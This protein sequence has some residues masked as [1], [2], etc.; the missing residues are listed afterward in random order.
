MVRSF[1]GS[2]NQSIHPGTQG[3]AG[4]RTGAPTGFFG[5]AEKDHA[6]FNRSIESSE[7]SLPLFLHQ[8]IRPS[9]VTLD[10]ILI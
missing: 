4:W 7:A 3:A 10:E 1:L 2:E 9:R 5:L 8:Q 6:W